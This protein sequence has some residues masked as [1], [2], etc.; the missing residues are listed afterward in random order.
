MTP[1]PRSPNKVRVC[2]SARFLA[3]SS[4]AG[5]ASGP[6]SPSIKAPTSA[7]AATA[8]V[9]GGQQAALER[10]SNADLEGAGERAPIA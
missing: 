6:I 7:A 8:G 5:E 9:L 3:G 4:V 10:A 1:R 2:T